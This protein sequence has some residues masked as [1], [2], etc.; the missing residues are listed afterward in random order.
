MKNLMMSIFL[1]ASISGCSADLERARC[2]GG[3]TTLYTDSYTNVG[4]TCDKPYSHTPEWCDYHG[5]GSECCVWVSEGT[6]REYCKWTYDS[7]YEFN[8]SF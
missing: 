1:V 4:D 6:H 8:G 5:D 2:A 3:G 7:C